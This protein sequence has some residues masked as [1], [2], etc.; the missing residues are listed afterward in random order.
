MLGTK[1]GVDYLFGKFLH[2]NPYIGYGDSEFDDPEYYDWH[3]GW[4]KALE[5]YPEL[6]PREE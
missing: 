6:E 2:N 1:G 5:C 4:M 3:D